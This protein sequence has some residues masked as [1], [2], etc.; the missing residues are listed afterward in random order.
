MQEQNLG[1]EGQLDAPVLAAVDDLALVLAE[2]PEGDPQL[3]QR[4]DNPVAQEQ[5]LEVERQAPEVHGREQPGGSNGNPAEEAVIFSPAHMAVI[6]DRLVELLPPTVLAAVL[7]GAT[8]PEELSGDD[9]SLSSELSTPDIMHTPSSPSTVRS[10]NQGP[11]CPDSPPPA[12]TSSSRSHDQDVA[13]QA[14]ENLTISQRIRA[15]QQVVE[16]AGEGKEKGKGKQQAWT[17]PSLP[18][19]EG[20]VRKAVAMWWIGPPDGENEN[21]A[22]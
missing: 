16:A 3:L 6:V 14:D 9:S 7:N 17:S 13:D 12:T 4:E 20:K 2:D 5:Q 11:L 19:S 21:D 10:H 15:L 8:S 18:I 22:E 1:D